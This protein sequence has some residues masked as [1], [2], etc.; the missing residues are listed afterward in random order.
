MTLSVALMG[1]DLIGQARTGTGKTLAFGIPVIRG[2]D[3]VRT[4]RREHRA[5]RQQPVRGRWTTGSTRRRSTRRCASRTTSSRRSRRCRA[6]SGAHQDDAGRIY[7]NTNESVLHVDV[8]PTRYYTRHPTLLRTRGSYESLEGDNNEVNATWPVRPTPGVNRGYQDGRVASRRHALQFTSVC[9]PIVY[10]GDRL[11]TELY[12]NVF[13]AEP[14]ANLVSRIIVERRG[15]AEAEQGV[16]RRGVP[17]STDERFRPVYLAPAPDGTFYIV[18]I[19]RGIIQHK[20]YIT[21]YLKGQIDSRNLTQPTGKGRIYR[22]VHDTTKRDVKPE[23]SKA[24]PA[25]LVQTLSHPNG[26]WR[27]TAQRL[28]VERGDPKAVAPL[29][30][31]ANEA[32]RTGKPVC[33][34]SGRSTARTRS[35]RPTL[36]KALNDPVARRARVRRSARGALAGSRLIRP[37]GGRAQAH[38]RSRAVRRQWRPRSASCRRIAREAPL[39]SML[40]KQATIRSRWMPQSAACAGARRRCS[41]RCWSATRRRP[42][43]KPRITMLAATVVRGATGRRVADHL[44]VDFRRRPADMAAIGA[45]SR[46]GS[47]VAEHDDAGDDGARPGRGPGSGDRTMSDVSG[48]ARGREGRRRLARRRWGGNRA[49]AVRPARSR[50]RGGCGRRRRSGRGRWRRWRARRARSGAETAARAGG[51]IAF[52]ERDRRFG[53][54]RDGAPGRLEWPGKPGA[55]AP[56]APLTPAEEQRFAP[57]SRSTRT[58]ARRVTRSMAA[59]WRR[60]RRR[61]SDR[62]FAL[63]P[64]R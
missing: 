41:T 4:A 57:A 28:L 61:W 49:P 12:G 19:Y 10:R 27:D 53:H 59:A 37:F 56:V 38:R 62:T 29:T 23:L 1:T 43:L 31:L 40:E 7:R 15:A 32:P 14:A 2:T 6:A 45:A 46:W 55:A 51:V 24:S 8:V 22:V 25:K 44:P 13:V 54:A 48:R 11:P 18:D 36:I 20:I 33:T 50:R 63:G 60:W 5:Q 16:S 42:R 47:S 58:S 64:A 26:W 52:A 39:A 3:H 35:H 17:G 34:R 21:E 9:S 30:T